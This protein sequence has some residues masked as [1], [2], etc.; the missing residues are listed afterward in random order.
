MSDTEH[1]QK[2]SDRTA[3]RREENKSAFSCALFGS[4]LCRP[5]VIT[6]DRNADNGYD[7]YIYE[8]EKQKYLVVKKEFYITS[9]G[10]S[11]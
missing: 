9:W 4:F 11:P 8:R 3:E 10:K 1:R 6:R 7:Q 5:F 2:H